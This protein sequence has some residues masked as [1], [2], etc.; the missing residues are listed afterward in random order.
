MLLHAADAWDCDE[1]RE[2]ARK[3]LPRCAQWNT[4]VQ[5]RLA[6]RYHEE[7]WFNGAFNT[8]V[9]TKA[10][11]LTE[12][13]RETLG[14]RMLRILDVA[15][16]S[17]DAHRKALACS[18]LPFTAGPECGRPITQCQAVFNQVWTDIGPYI[19]CSPQGALRG[20][21]VLEK[22]ESVLSDL[23]EICGGCQVLSLEELR[24]RKQFVKEDAIIAECQTE[25]YKL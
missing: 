21:E 4:V 14:H 9:W 3:H 22:L 20:K 13:E 11:D 16:D 18:A 10:S 15:R 25:A 1:A 17:V 8:L 5:L 12:S 23:T 24:V 7:E 2:Y 6:L 19:L